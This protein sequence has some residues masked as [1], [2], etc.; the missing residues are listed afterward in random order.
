[1]TVTE[2]VGLVRAAYPD[3]DDVE[4]HGGDAVGTD[5]YPA[6]RDAWPALV[7]A[8]RAEAADVR[9]AAAYALAFIVERAAQTQ[10]ALDAA[11]AAAAMPLEKAA[12]I[13]AAG[14]L[15]GSFELW[16]EREP[17]RPFD[18]Y[19][20]PTAAVR[21][22]VPVLRAAH[23]IAMLFR[24]PSWHRKVKPDVVAA[25]EG[26]DGIAVG[27]WGDGDVGRLARAIGEG[28]F[29]EP[30][31][32]GAHAVYGGAPAEAFEDDEPVA[33]VPAL[34][35]SDDVPRDEEITAHVPISEQ[36]VADPYTQERPVRA[37]A[38]RV[39][40]PGLHDVDWSCLEHAYGKATGVPAM[41]DALSSPDAADRA[42]AREALDA[43]IHHQGSVYSSSGPAA[44][45]LIQ[46]VER[47]EVEDRAW[48][49]ELLAGLAVHSPSWRLFDDLE[50]AASEAFA[51][52]SAGGPAFVRLL[53]DP[54][55]EVRT[56]AAY[57]LSF[58]TPPD[59]ANIAVKRALAMETNRYVR[60]SMVL[61]LGY[62]GRRTKST[63]DRSVVERYLDDDCLL[64]AASAALA[65]A[66]IDRE[67]CSPRVRAMLA[68]TITDVPPVMGA[69]PWND[70]DVAGFARAVRLAILTVEEMLDE[71]DAAKAR[72]DETSAHEYAVKTCM[73]RFRDPVH[74][75]KRPWV[76]RELDETQRRILRF[77][78][79]ISHQYEGATEPQFPMDSTTAYSSGL[80]LVVD[81]VKRLVGDATG[82]LDR[83]IAGSPAWFAIGEVVGERAS[84]ESLRAAFSTIAP[85]ERVE[86]IEDAMSGPF[87]LHAN[88]EPIDFANPAHY[89]RDKDYTSRFILAMAAL[90]G[91]A[92]LVGHAYARRIAEEQVTQQYPRSMRC[93][94]AAIALA[95]HARANGE[96]PPA[97]IDRLVLTDQAPASTY[98]GAIRA[99]LDL[100]APERRVRLLGDLPL[101]T[102]WS[103]RDP[104]GEVRRWHNERGW[105]MLDFLEPAAC[106][107]KVGAA[108]TEW[109]RH[110][111]A[112][113]DAHAQPVSGTS[114]ST[115][116]QDPGADQEFPRAR[117]IELL[118]ACGDAGRELLDQLTRSTSAPTMSTS[119]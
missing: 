94:I 100:L 13:L 24:A 108:W 16:R 63:A 57:V 11:V 90:L 39:E 96:E 81:A 53:A 58:V 107:A 1:M 43:S 32:G 18:G 109:L 80:P 102:Y 73:R 106:A 87:T 93:L 48:I 97:I 12:M 20:L 30:G 115:M 34:R 103:Y 25:L 38:P 31:H 71:A 85:A 28:L 104:R 99:A 49:L 75:V 59:G 95:T 68:K 119:L 50:D 117:A 27:P 5:A 79:S 9:M 112:G 89:E 67:A 6:L 47:T 40:L 45:F 86:M 17:D 52:V 111:G 118:T 110:R 21:E 55:P 101:Y 4:K 7:E 65:M 46:L 70:G 66:Q 22:R 116:N 60:S 35:D 19:E 44:T 3:V 78:I 76:P 105:D 51:E 62:I 61:A 33:E 15:R 84:L 42:W 8:L 10:A 92:E 14:R 114:S 98:R 36:E 56:C 2:I 77:L 88:R 74:G 83:E 37:A 91:D 72:G 26:L 82:P 23:V 54:E 113:D 41:I 64:I 29:A 69:W